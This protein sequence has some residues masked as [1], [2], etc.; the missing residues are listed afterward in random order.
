MR[1]REREFPLPGKSLAAA[2]LYNLIPENDLQK[3]HRT[4][5]NVKYT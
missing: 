2:A 3:G 1:Q 5:E 4:P